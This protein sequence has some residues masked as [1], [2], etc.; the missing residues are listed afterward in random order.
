[1][2]GYVC[3][4]GGD[5]KPCRAI[6]QDGAGMETI[7]LRVLEDYVRR[8]IARVKECD[9]DIEIRHLSSHLTMIIGSLEAVD[10]IRAVDEATDVGDKDN[11]LIRK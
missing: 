3:G 10:A 1:V 2:H 9:K 4:V 8:F 5:S 7:A 6:A 11:P